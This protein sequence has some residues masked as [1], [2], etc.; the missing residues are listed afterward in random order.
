MSES[1]QQK[2]YATRIVLLLDSSGSM[3]TIKKSTIESYNKFIEDQQKSNPRDAVKF[4]LVKFSTE[5]TEL[6]P[7]ELHDVP[8]LSDETFRPDG[9]TALYDAMAKIIDELGVELYNTPQP[10]RPSSVIMVILTD[11]EENSS[12]KF[13]SKDVF[14][15]VTH[16]Q[17][18]YSWRFIYLGANQDAIKTANR[19]GITPESAIDYGYNEKS[20]ACAMETCSKALSH[21]VT[22]GKCYSFSDEDR[23]YCF[24]E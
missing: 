18:K 2:G 5:C 9:N 20:M 12:F 7:I 11:G 23:Q 8:K 4:S 24:A 16:Q 3:A 17:E 19:M 22:T 6:V 10:L 1:S 14:D 21:T 13:T 15:R